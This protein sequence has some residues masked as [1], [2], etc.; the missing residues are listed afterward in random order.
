MGTCTLELTDREAK[1][2]RT[3]LAIRLVGMREELVHT[4]DRAYRAGLKDLIERLELVQQRIERFAGP[5]P[6]RES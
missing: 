1:D 5:V 4:D 6:S 2:L 3:A